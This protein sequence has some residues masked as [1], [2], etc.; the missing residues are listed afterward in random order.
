MKCRAVG[1]IFVFCIAVAVAG[2]ETDVAQSRYAT[3]ADARVDHLFERGW[4]PDLL[5]PT[6]TDIHT[7]NNL[8]VDTSTGSFRFPRSE[9]PQLFGRLARGV[10]EAPFSDWSIRVAS[11][12]MRGFS[13]WSYEEGDSQWAFFCLAEV[14]VCEYTSW[15]R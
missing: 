9:G 12:E 1:P 5:P 4:L 13:L 8:D 6:A 10:P 7:V 3:L 2:C 14:G 15:T 11:Y